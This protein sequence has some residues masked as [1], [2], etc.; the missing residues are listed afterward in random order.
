[1]ATHEQVHCA[2]GHQLPPGLRDLGQSVSQPGWDPSRLDLELQFLPFFLTDAVKPAIYK[3]SEE[4]A[5]LAEAPSSRASLTNSTVS[6]LPPLENLP[7]RA[8]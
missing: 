3:V 4:P 7:P 8:D 2:C 5:P 6:L 1:M